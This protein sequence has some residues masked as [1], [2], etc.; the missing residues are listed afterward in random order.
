MTETPH[1]ELQLGMVW[2]GCVREE[3][4]VPVRQSRVEEE[5]LSRLPGLWKIKYAYGAVLQ[6]SHILL[7]RTKQRWSGWP[8]T[9]PLAV[10]LFHQC[11]S[12]VPIQQET[13]RLSVVPAVAEVKDKSGWWM[14][15]S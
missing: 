1:P 9:F 15:G 4:F 8:G 6:L 13:E 5:P 7:T 10:L 2:L 11:L 12:V 3:G 14:A